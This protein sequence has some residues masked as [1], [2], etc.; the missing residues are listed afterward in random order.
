MNTFLRR[1][2]DEGVNLIV[3]INGRTIFSSNK[4]GMVPLLEAIEKINTS[5][6][7]GFT[8]IDKIVG[9]AAALLIC[10]L[11]AKK[12]YTRMMSLKAVKVLD[13]HSIEY[14]AEKTIPDIL[15]KSGTGIC[16]FEK[17]VSDTNNPEEAYKRLRTC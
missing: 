3:I 1:L 8:I 2:D 9:K 11:Q 16:P 4:D 13:D 5:E 7:S 12:V 10:L 14:S 15:N 6:L 17:I